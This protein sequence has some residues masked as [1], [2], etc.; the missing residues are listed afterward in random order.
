MSI[1]KVEGFIEVGENES[2]EIVINIPPNQ[3]RREQHATNC[4][5]RGDLDELCNCGVQFFSPNQARNLANLLN[6]H[7]NEAERETRRKEE[8]AR[9]KAAEAIPVDYNARTLLDGSPVT[10]DH[11]E[12]EPAT[13]MQKSYVVLSAEERAKGFVRPVRRS[14]KHLKCGAVTSMGQALAE[15]YA[16][17]P[18]FYTGTYCVQCCDHLPV[19]EDGEF[20]WVD[21][22]SKV[23][24]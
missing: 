11:R 10:D 20:V 5:Y 12:I 17:C 9:R 22:G 6:K 13:G 3:K 2:G 18:T 15:T 8:E 14:Y 21:D 7:A 16:R 4:A 1:D 19:G 24:T 23:G